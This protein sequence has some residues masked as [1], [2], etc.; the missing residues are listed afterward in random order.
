MVLE[1]MKMELDVVAP[2]DG[3]ISQLCSEQGAQVKAGQPL[4][5]IDEQHSSEGM[6]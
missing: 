5:V 3:Q 1:A 4:M 6:I 2:C